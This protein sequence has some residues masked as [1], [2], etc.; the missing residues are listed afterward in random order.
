MEEGYKFE[1]QH[2]FFPLLKWVIDLVEFG[3]E[4]DRF[5]VGVAVVNLANFASVLLMYEVVR[6]AYNIS[7]KA[8]LYVAMF[9]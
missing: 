4:V 6:R 9:F 8:S 2:V 1:R 3:V 7:K 5:W